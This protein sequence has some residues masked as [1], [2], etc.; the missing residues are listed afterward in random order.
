ME[1]RVGILWGRFSLPPLPGPRSA[2]HQ[3]MARPAD[4]RALGQRHARG[5]EA[6]TPRPGRPRQAHVTGRRRPP[7]AKAAP[8]EGLSGILKSIRANLPVVGLVSALTAPE[9]GVLGE[10]SYSEYSRT[11]YSNAP[12]GFGGACHSLSERYGKGAN[13]RNL[14]FCCWAAD[15]GTGFVERAELEKAARR[16]AITLDLEFEIANFENE[17]DNGKKKGALTAASAT[18]KAE[19][20]AFMI[21]LVCTAKPAPEDDGALRRVAF[22]TRGAHEVPAHTRTHARPRRPSHRQTCETTCSSS[23]AARFPRWRR[24][25]CLLRGR[26]TAVPRWPTER[27]CRRRGGSRVALQCA[28]GICSLV[29]S[30]RRFRQDAHRPFGLSYTCVTLCAGPKPRLRRSGGQSAL[31]C[32]FPRRCAVVPR[33]TH[34]PLTASWLT[35]NPSASAPSTA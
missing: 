25:W 11:L 22:P 12:P 26:A 29:F 2:A 1:V 13:Y 14:V 19:L 24:R 5:P 34:P 27:L 23:C 17:R 35:R 15:A 3:A 32:C 33:S 4:A 9:G 16:V 18:E 31:P 20:A 6:R 7:V 30:G 8:D 21:C 28:R 10:L